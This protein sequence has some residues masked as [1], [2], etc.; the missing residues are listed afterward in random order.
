[1]SQVKSVI[2]LLVLAF[3]LVSL[4]SLAKTQ[5]DSRGFTVKIGDPLP[6]FS[7]ELDD[8]RKLKPE[9]FKG[10]VVMLQFTAS[11]CGVCIH[12]MPFIEKEIWQKH[13]NNKDFML[14]GVDIDEPLDVVKELAQD[15][16]ISYPLGLDPGSKIFELF[17][18]EYAGVTR[19]VIIDKTGKIVF[20]TRLF[21]RKEF[22]QMKA[23]I[24]KL[25]SA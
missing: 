9:D 18:E 16:G 12:E 2:K 25:L 5:D 17:T 11:W 22:N 21:E 1:M 3:S 13:K 10:K 15:T 20:L 6:S 14:I 8:G 24:D 7:I 4:A 19:N 23:V